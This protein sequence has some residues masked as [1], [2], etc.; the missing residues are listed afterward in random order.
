MVLKM[1]SSSRPFESR[2]DSLNENTLLC[3]ID[4]LMRSIVLGTV[5]L[6]LPQSVQIEISDHFAET[7]RL[8]LWGP[9]R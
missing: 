1:L 6:L 8:K 9:Y 2:S 3:E 7:E 5:K 4:T